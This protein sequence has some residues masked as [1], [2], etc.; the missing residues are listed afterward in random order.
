MQLEGLF[1]ACDWLGLQG[2]YVIDGSVMP[3]SL[4]A[5]PLLT[6][7]AIAEYANAMMLPDMGLRSLISVEDIYR[8]G[9]VT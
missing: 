8:V 3:H 6:I 7:T 1:I 2:L 9:N 4:G 5:N